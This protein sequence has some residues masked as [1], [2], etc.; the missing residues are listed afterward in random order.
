MK[1]H[2]AQRL[3]MIVG[4]LA[5]LGLAVGLVLF[6]LRENINHFYPPTEMLAE[7]PPAHRVVRLGGM[8][9]KDSLKRT[10]G[11]TKV[12]FRVTDYQTSLSVV[13]E[14]ILP[15]LFREGQGIVAMGRLIQT[16]DGFLFEATEVL[17]KHDE[18]YM[19]PEVQAGLKEKTPVSPKSGI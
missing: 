3:A 18:N 6:A 19:P 14:G 11:S 4:V 16:P 5:V 12:F 7:N 17:A 9:E 15:D 2:R 13:F 1:K 8:V 10:K